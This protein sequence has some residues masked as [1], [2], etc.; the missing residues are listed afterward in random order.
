MGNREEG[1]KREEGRERE[2]SNGRRERER[3]ERRKREGDKAKREDKFNDHNT[4]PQSS[5]YMIA[6]V[7]FSCH[8][9]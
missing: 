9:H 5:P 3:D 6:T 4:K 2:R 7:H 8:H 1:R